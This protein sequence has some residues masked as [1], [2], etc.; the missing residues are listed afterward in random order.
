M[1]RTSTVVLNHIADL[2]KLR[3]AFSGVQLSLVRTIYIH[4]DLKVP[5]MVREDQLTFTLARSIFPRVR[6]ILVDLE[7]CV[8]AEIVGVLPD[9]YLWQEL[10]HESLSP[11]GQ[12][13]YVAYPNCPGHCSPG[14]AEANAE[15]H[16]SSKRN[17]DDKQAPDVVN[18]IV[19]SGPYLFKAHQPSKAAE[20]S[21]LGRLLVEA[22]ASGADVLCTGGLSVV[23]TTCGCFF[24]LKVCGA[25]TLVS[26]Q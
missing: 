9:S 21:R 10:I 11:Q 13:D 6:N 15:D 16:M 26:L 22:K 18:T 23:C 8:S 20:R 14:L 17:A 19:V 5:Y 2:D 4:F 12:Y 24:R 1:L 25:T 3:I 7:G